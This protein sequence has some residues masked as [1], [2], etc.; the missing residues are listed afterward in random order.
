MD[1]GAP[2]TDELV[3]PEG[4]GMQPLDRFYFFWLLLQGPKRT[5]IA[6]PPSASEVHQVEGKL[7][8]H[9]QNQGETMKRR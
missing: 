7:E 8:S 9:R 6:P 5:A 3:V 1:F 4:P 2:T